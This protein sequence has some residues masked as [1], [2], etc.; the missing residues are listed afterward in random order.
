MPAEPPVIT[1]DWL[2]MLLSHKNP[3]LPLSAVDG[4]FVAITQDGVSFI[5]TPN[6]DYI[7]SPPNYSSNTITRRLDG[8][9]GQEDY[10]HWP[11]PYNQ[12]YPHHACILRKQTS[13]PYAV[14]W[15]DL[16]F[17]NHFISVEHNPRMGKITPPTLDGL[18]TCVDNLI[19]RA[20]IWKQD[21]STS[22]ALT[23][24]NPLMLSLSHA[25]S[26]LECIALTFS[27]T[28]LVLRSVQRAWLEL[29]AVIEYVDVFQQRMN[30][31]VTPPSPYDIAP[32]IGAFVSVTRQ[33]QDLFTA[34]IPFWFIKPLN[35]FTIENILEPISLTCPPWEL[36][37]FPMR[38][39]PTLLS[40]LS[41]PGHARIVAIAQSD[42]EILTYPNPFQSAPPLEITPPVPAPQSIRFAP[43]KVK[44]GSSEQAKASFRVP[45]DAFHPLPN[46]ELIPN[47]L[48]LWEKA[49][50]SVKIDPNLLIDPSR[51]RP[52]DGKYMFPPLR[53]FSH[54]LKNPTR[55]AR[56]LATWTSIREPCIYRA[57]F[58]EYTSP[59]LSTQAW[60]DLLLAA[61]NQQIDTIFQSMSHVFDEFGID[62]QRL[63]AQN[64]MSTINQN[65]V[66]QAMWELAE[67]NFRSD[68]CALDARMLK[69]TSVDHT[70][71]QAKLQSCLAP[72]DS[73]QTGLFIFDYRAGTTGLGAVEIKQKAHVLEKLRSL[74]QDWEH[75][76]TGIITGTTISEDLDFLDR[77]EKAIAVCFCQG[78]FNCFGRAANI[79]YTLQG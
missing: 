55:L 60:R 18:R 34:R 29:H 63:S 38:T 57:M 79:P 51:R 62:R 31:R 52:D 45:L 39:Q 53:I 20:H 75:G 66:K 61:D 41:D 77:L 9:F 26:Q 4:K 1:K 73:T 74:M 56:F 11:Q 46:H 78:F 17:E 67:Y 5:T 59:P 37:A 69:R 40:S 65:E 50:N 32:T 16:D 7:P 68:L 6:A 70:A 72:L 28:I 47:R 15:M 43:Y 13:G 64:P 10:I 76:M 49:L 8:R 14:M 44:S 24:V 27:N 42:R 19:S 36:L 58:N 23:L 21:N 22:S 35:R 54:T 48:L 25:I 2:D 71:H 33:A 30:G 12:R 3:D